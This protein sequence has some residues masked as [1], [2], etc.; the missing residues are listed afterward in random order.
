MTTTEARFR[1]V[2]VSASVVRSV[3]VSVAAALVLTTLL[4]ACGG[5]DGG[6]DGGPGGGPGE[7]ADVRSD[8]PRPDVTA[9]LEVVPGDDTVVVS[10]TVT[11]DGDVPL[12]LANRLPRVAGAGTSFDDTLAYVT[13]AGSDAVEIS[14]R[15]FPWPAGD[16]ERAQ[17]PQIGAT[18]LE[19]GA[20][21]TVELA[22]PLPLERNQPFGDD[23][24]DKTITLPDPVSR[25]S[26]CLGL[27][28][29][30][31]TDAAPDQDGVVLLGHGGAAVDLQYLLCSEA[32]DLA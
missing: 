14:Q 18:V 27:L 25:V 26:F 8:V 13:G 5:S 21:V 2:S 23:L 32:V 17:A 12:L 1:S 10:Y 4:V 24:G 16:V 30:D 7:P 6:S 29:R 28:P 3:A 20:T 9:D 11:N 22:V 15:L 31:V 19:P